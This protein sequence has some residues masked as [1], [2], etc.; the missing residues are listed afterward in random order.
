MPA[1]LWGRCQAKF[2]FEAGEIYVLLY[3]LAY[4]DRSSDKNYVK[5]HVQYP[6]LY[7]V[8]S[9]VIQNITFLLPFT[10][11]QSHDHH[12]NLSQLCVLVDFRQDEHHCAWGSLGRFDTRPK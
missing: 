12:L 5:W 2:D 9:D 7:A 6:N 11:R 4:C 1:R 3:F 8:K 10:Q